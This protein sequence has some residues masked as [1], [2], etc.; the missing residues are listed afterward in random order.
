MS[1][2]CKLCGAPQESGSKPTKVITRKRDRVYPERRRK[3]RRGDPKPKGRQPKPLSITYELQWGG[4]F[5]PPF[6]GHWVVERVEHWGDDPGGKGWEIA[7]EVDACL[8][9]VS[10]RTDQLTHRAASAPVI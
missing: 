4:P 9:C 5:W 1:F 7:E 2:R 10:R 3:P 6:E 8:A